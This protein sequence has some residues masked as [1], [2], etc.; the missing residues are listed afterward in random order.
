MLVLCVEIERECMWERIK[1]ASNRQCTS[2]FSLSLSLSHPSLSLILASLSCHPTLASLSLLLPAIYSSLSLSLSLFIVTLLPLS[3][4]LV[5]RSPPRPSLSF[6]SINL[7]MMHHLKRQTTF[8]GV[9][10]P[11]SWHAD[12]LIYDRHK[13]QR[14]QQTHIT[15]HRLFT[16]PHY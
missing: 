9:P 12:V 3:C 2:I 5:L 8:S 13:S 15:R 6:S 14:H 11:C 16:L 7:L 4:H 10:L 1:N